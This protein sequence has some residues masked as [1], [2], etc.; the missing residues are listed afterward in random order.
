MMDPYA[1]IGMSPQTALY[2]RL[3]VRLHLDP[4]YVNHV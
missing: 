4:T 2:G 3:V 1:R